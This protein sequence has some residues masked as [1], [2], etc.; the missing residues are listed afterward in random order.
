[1]EELFDE[2]SDSGIDHFSLQRWTTS[3]CD[4]WEEEVLYQGLFELE[5]S[6]TRQ[7]SISLCM[8]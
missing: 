1:M 3:V 4:R 8:Q 7:I 5:D 2:E 6:R